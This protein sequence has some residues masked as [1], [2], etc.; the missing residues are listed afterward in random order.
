MNCVGRRVSI[1]LLLLLSVAASNALAQDRNGITGFVFGPDRAPV[2]RLYVE[3]Q[4]ELYSTVARTQTNGSGMFAFRGLPQGLYIV[5]ILTG[6]TDY[7]EQS[8]SIS[9]VPISARG[10]VSEQ[11]DFY[12][13]VRTRPGD[14]QGPGG[15]VFV[16]NV[17]KAAEQL[18]QMALADFEKKNETDAYEKL[19]QALKTFPDYYLALDRLA[20]EYLA[21][22]YYDAA[23]ILFTKA[24]GVYPRS[25]SS[26]LG[27]G[28]A[29]YRLNRSDKAVESF[30]AVLKLDKENVNALYWKGIVLHSSKKLDD[31]LAAFQRADRLSNGKFAEVHFQL[32]KVY[33]D[34]HKFRESADAL[35]KF[36]KLRPEAQNAAEIRQIIKVLREKPSS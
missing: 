14:I 11:A 15:V 35:E 17:P 28:I 22:G 13:R 24:F 25:I 10:S 32:A 8:R 7:I 2:D 30:D 20:T 4:T 12:L 26:G 23:Q 27:L 1:L 9:L 36:L 3:L 21:K 34:Q 6:G 5:K 33:K 31:S 19:K 29:E 18:Y 16:Q